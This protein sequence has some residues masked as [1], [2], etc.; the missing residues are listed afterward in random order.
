MNYFNLKGM[1]IMVTGAAGH[2]GSAISMGLAEYG[3][4]VFLN[5]RDK[6]KL[7]KLKKKI[8]EVKLSSEIAHF[9]IENFQEVE[10]FF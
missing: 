3:A 1:N 6:K 8:N 2:I 9:D 5:G 7:L 10:N 4:K